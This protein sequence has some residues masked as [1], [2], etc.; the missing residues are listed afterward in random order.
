VH[1]GACG[2]LVLVDLCWYMCPS[3]WPVLRVILNAISTG[4]SEPTF[5]RNW[6][7]SDAIEQIAAATWLHSLHCVLIVW[8]KYM[9]IAL[10]TW[11]ATRLRLT[12]KH[13]V[14]CCTVC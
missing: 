14:C 2:G 12:D 5:I 9:L 13:L 7:Q 11:I 6:S 3:K 10:L 4:K 1:L 8:S